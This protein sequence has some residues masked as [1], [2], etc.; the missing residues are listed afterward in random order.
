MITQ[1]N[2]LRQ[3]FR[4]KDFSSQT[5]LWVGGFE[6]PQNRKLFDNT[7]LLLHIL[8]RNKQ[9]TKKSGFFFIN[10][11]SITFKKEDMFYHFYLGRKVNSYLP[12]HWLTAVKYL[13]RN[14]VWIN[15]SCQDK[16]KFKWSFLYSMPFRRWV[17]K[18]LYN[19]LL[20]LEICNP[21]PTFFALLI[22]VLP[23]LKRK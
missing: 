11:R 17:I 18:A 4:T 10:Q 23:L 15:N 16:Q 2:V 19:F 9:G 20:R 21:L 14:N 13:F 8:K 1:S 12:G 22:L 3:F 6:W 5:S 7:C